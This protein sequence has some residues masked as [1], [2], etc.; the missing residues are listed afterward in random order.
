M[1]VSDSENAPVGLP[2]EAAEQRAAEERAS[3]PERRAEPSARSGALAGV[4]GG[5]VAAILVS[6]LLNA[7]GWLDR[8]D[9]VL[10]Q[11][12]AALEGADQ[13]LRADAARSVQ[14]LAALEGRP[15]PEPDLTPLREDAAALRGEIAALRDALATQ[16]TA[17]EM[18]RSS[19]DQGVRELRET[20]GGF[21]LSL[22]EQRSRIDT[23]AAQRPDLEPLR[24]EIGAVQSALGGVKSEMTAQ[25]GR[26]ADLAKRVG[27]LEQTLVSARVSSTQTAGLA[28]ALVE[29]DRALDAG[30]PL[31]SAL[32]PFVPL[33]ADPAVKAPLDL[34]QPL[35]T[36]GAPT[37]AELQAKLAELRPRIAEAMRHPDGTDW[38]G[39]TA[40]NLASLVDLRKVDAAE[41][42][43]TGR[44]DEAAQALAR[45]E[46][47]AAA[48]VIRPLAEGGNA[49]AGEWLELAQRRLD[50]E[51]GLERLRAYL[52]AHL[53]GSP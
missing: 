28:L 1:S 38:L 50:G 32:E 37:V 45:G 16:K 19:L 36:V 41:A 6:F 18:A 40:A 2:P 47:D 43:A 33:A 26:L 12:I 20:T 35:R 10:G 14:R 23:L 7:S 29:L 48:A 42:A 52:A 24:A 34:L 13:G 49:V 21:G 17:L 4:V 27:A 30:E 5:A 31:A 3:V 11:R 39:Q 8:P 46:V 22:A 25:A 44:L 51:A 53:P 9:P 15:P